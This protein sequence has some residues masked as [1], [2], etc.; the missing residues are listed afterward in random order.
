MISLPSEITLNKDKVPAQDAVIFLTDKYGNTSD[1]TDQIMNIT[2]DTVS[3]LWHINFIGNE[4]T[5][6]YKNE[7]VKL[8]KNSLKDKASVAVFDYLMQMAGFND[9]KNE[10]GQNLLVKRLEKA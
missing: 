5:F 6:C 9:I 4:K 3:K 10:E 1:K 2:Y 7:N 8:I